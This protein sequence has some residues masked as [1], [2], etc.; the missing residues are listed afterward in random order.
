MALLLCAFVAFAI[1]WSSSPYFLAFALAFLAFAVKFVAFAVTFSR[2]SCS[3]IPMAPAR[4]RKYNAHRGVDERVQAR[5]A[6]AESKAMTAKRWQQTSML[7]A[8]ANTHF[9]QDELLEQR[10]HM[11]LHCLGLC[12][13]AHAIQTAVPCHITLI[14]Y[15]RTAGYRKSY[16]R[17]VDT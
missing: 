12:S 4:P 15:V 17:A 1:L 3:E 16:R 14:F 6:R 8:G 13:V 11:S 10:A 7:E 5:L 9:R 2:A